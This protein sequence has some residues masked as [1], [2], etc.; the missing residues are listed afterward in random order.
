MSNNQ[1]NIVATKYQQ[2]N[3]WWLNCSDLFRSLSLYKSLSRCNKY[4]PCLPYRHTKNCVVI[5]ISDSTSLKLLQSL[6]FRV[7][8]AY[9]HIDTHIH[10]CMHICICICG[11]EGKH[12]YKFADDEN[13]WVSGIISMHVYT[14]MHIWYM[15]LHDTTRQVVSGSHLFNLTNWYVWWGYT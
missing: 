2:F 15:M 4:L 5:S 13:E 11:K 1:S 8:Y 14:I 12:T 6:Q 9:I 3:Y 7:V 10:L